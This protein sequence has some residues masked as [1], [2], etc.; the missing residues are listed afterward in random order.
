MKAHLQQASGR[1]GQGNADIIL[2]AEHFGV[3]GDRTTDNG[4]VIQRVVAERRRQD[5]PAPRRFEL[6]DLTQKLH[7]SVSV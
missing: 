2:N 3:I 4:K 7:S 1:V 5:E 6:R